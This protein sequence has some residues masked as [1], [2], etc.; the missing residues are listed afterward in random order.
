MLSM[1]NLA[2]DVS[3]FVEK[4]LSTAKTVQLASHV[5][6]CVVMSRKHGAITKLKQDLISTNC[7]KPPPIHRTID[8]K[9]GS[10]MFFQM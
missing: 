6:N 10:K 4:R 3:I 2:T 1:Y 5:G 9:S 8:G 7:F